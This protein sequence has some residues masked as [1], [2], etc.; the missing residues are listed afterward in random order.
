MRAFNADVYG[1]FSI[2]SLQSDLSQMTHVILSNHSA[3]K[4]KLFSRRV[5]GKDVVLMR[6]GRR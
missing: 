6:S 3:A 2:F 1:Y 5:S 4:K